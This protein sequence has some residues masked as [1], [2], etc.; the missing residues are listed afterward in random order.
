MQTLHCIECGQ[1]VSQHDQG[2]GRL[3]GSWSLEFKIRTSGRALWLG[4]ES[5]TAPGCPHRVFS[6]TIYTMPLP[7]IAE[8]IFKGASTVALFVKVF[9]ALLWLVPVA[10]LKL[11][12]GGASNTSER[13]MHSKVVMITVN[14]PLLSNYLP[15]T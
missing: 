11:Y 9:K 15:F 10:L 7:F 6:I 8:S 4:D 1:S 14:S 12:F 5:I 2:V 13:L 3:G